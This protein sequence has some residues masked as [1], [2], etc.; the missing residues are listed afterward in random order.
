MN[1]MGEFE[2]EKDSEGIVLKIESVKNA[3]QLIITLIDTK[4][5]YQDFYIVNIDDLK[6][7]IRKLTAT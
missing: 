1:F 5:D 7:A 3:D 2:F 4:K 6:L